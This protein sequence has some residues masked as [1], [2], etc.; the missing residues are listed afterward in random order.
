MNNWK[1]EPIGIKFYSPA[2]D[3]TV[4]K[5]SHIIA[6]RLLKFFWAEV[7][8]FHG[9]CTIDTDYSLEAIREELEHCLNTPVTK[10]ESF[11]R[12]L[13]RNTWR[14]EDKYTQGEFEPL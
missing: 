10:G 8:S 5:N 9:I 4:N 13:N 12:V 6:Q 7:D 1:I 2:L 11:E 3:S 14:Y